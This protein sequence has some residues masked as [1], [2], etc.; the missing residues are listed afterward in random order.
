[1]DNN[2][3][4]NR[5]IKSNVSKVEKSN[6][7][8]YRIRKFLIMEACINFDYAFVYPSFSYNISILGNSHEN[9]LKHLP[10]AHKRVIRCN[11]DT[12]CNAH[13]SLQFKK[14]QLLKL[15][16]IVEYVLCIHMY[17]SIKAHKY[18]PARRANTRNQN[19]TRLSFHRFAMCQQ[20]VSYTGS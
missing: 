19:E 9:T 20:A 5:H 3:K 17:K 2:L 18:S 15:E 12:E 7:V 14:Y 6:A 11:A 8:L 16:D 10:I 4:F 1:M 13:S